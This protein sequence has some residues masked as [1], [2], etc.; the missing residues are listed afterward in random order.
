M[1][2]EDDSGVR[3]FATVALEELGYQVL[4]A[5]DADEA[6]RILERASRVDAMFTMWSWAAA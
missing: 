2:V 3:D 5:A 6:L 1:L 4:A